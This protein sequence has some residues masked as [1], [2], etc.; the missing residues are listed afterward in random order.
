MATRCRVSPPHDSPNGNAVALLIHWP[1][2]GP[3]ASKIPLDVVGAGLHVVVGLRVHVHA[4]L[5]QCK[6]CAWVCGVHAYTLRMHT[7]FCSASFFFASS[8][9]ATRA[10]AI[11]SAL[12]TLD[13]VFTPLSFRYAI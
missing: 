1:H 4:W 11:S 3:Q 7:C 8:S 6:G 13:A 5:H 2:Q 10:A 12:A 9:S